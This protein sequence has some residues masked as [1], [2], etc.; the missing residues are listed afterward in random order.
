[1]NPFWNECTAQKYQQLGFSPADY[2]LILKVG[3]VKVSAIEHPFMGV[4]LIFESITSRAVC[5]YESSAPANCSVEQIAGLIYLNVA[6][7]FR[8]SASL[9]KAYF[10]KLGI[11][12]F[13]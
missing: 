6:E 7:N 5:Q 12:L 11:P 8:D 10:Q 4:A 2:S 9:F 3:N 13:Q 1:M